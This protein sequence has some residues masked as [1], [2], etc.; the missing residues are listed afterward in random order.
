MNRDNDVFQVL[1]PSGQST[2]LANDES[3]LSSLVAG[4]IGIFES[5]TTKSIDAADAGKKDFRLA[6]ALDTDGDGVVDKIKFQAGQY[7]QVKNLTDISIRGYKNPKPQVVIINP[8]VSSEGTTDGIYEEE[9][10]I[11]IN[12]LN[13]RIS[14]LQGQNQFTKYYNTVGG[15][16]V[17][18]SS[19]FSVEAKKIA[20]MQ[21]LV[22]LI[23]DDPDGLVLAELVTIDGFYGDAEYTSLTISDICAYLTANTNA[24]LLRIRLTT[25]PIAIKN[26]IGINTGY[27][28]DRETSIEVFLKDDFLTTS[29]VTTLRNIQYEQGSGY[30]VF[31]REYQAE[32]WEESPYRTSV[33]TG[34]PR[35]R[36]IEAVVTT[37][38]NIVSLQYKFDSDAGWGHYTHNLATEIAIPVADTAVWTAFKALL[39]YI[40]TNNPMINY[41]LD[42]TAETVGVIA[43]PG[44]LSGEELLL[45][46]ASIDTISPTDKDMN[47]AAANNGSVTETLVINIKDGEF[48]ADIDAS[49]IT[50][51]N[52]ITGLTLVATRTD[53][54]TLTLSWTGNASSHL[55]A[56]SITDY[57]IS[58]D[59][60]KITG[61]DEDLS[62][63]GIKFTF[64]GS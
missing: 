44:V 31:E 3:T 9:H 63:T 43:D 33:V 23:N 21:E 61:A 28:K 13:P 37:K 45:T 47:E 59:K 57:A 8:Q 55:A 20:I 14:R 1:V 16:I 52:K 30:D 32:G 41:H 36:R 15:T 58:I 24:D 10:G 2:I 48:A 7:I 64:T 26:F 4:Q 34:L 49:D 6:V 54:N 46:P 22:E 50:E 19:A 5:K 12:F 38:Y 40:Y 11:K 39:A 56:D 62:V 29:T 35:D 27:Y 53:A 42:G 18:C 25:V 17:E 60:D 51:T